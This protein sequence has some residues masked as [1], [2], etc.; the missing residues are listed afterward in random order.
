VSPT[1]WRTVVAKEG[2]GTVVT[3]FL[4]A[5]S[6][7]ADQPAMGVRI[8]GVEQQLQGGARLAANGWTHLAASYDGATLR[9]YVNGVQVASRAQTGAIVATTNPLRIGGNG[10]WGEYF[11][12]RIDEVRIYNRALSQSE[13]QSD[14][15]TPLSP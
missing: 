4:H 6:L 15:N 5:S 7:S 2:A 8:G 13:I 12:G 3:Y 9:L 1:A 14:M 10:V 11:Q